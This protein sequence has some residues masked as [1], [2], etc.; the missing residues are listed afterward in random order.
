MCELESAHNKATSYH[1]FTKVGNLTARWSVPH[2]SQ[3]QKLVSSRS[4]SLLESF[5]GNVRERS[6][7]FCLAPSALCGIIEFRSNSCWIVSCSEILKVVFLVRCYTRQEAHHTVRANLQGIHTEICNN[8]SSRC[9]FF[10]FSTIFVFL[11][12]VLFFVRRFTGILV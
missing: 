6:L 3:L 5:L 1:N 11:A 12:R 9:D 2:S 4:L 8:N 10:S 7:E